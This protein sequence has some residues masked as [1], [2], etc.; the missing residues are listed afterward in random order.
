MTD[1]ECKTT[2]DQPVW[3]FAIGSMMNSTSLRGRKLYPI[4]SKPCIIQ[5]FRLE[6]LGRNG[7]AGAIAASGQSFHGVA[8]LMKAEQMKVLDTIESGYLRTPATA[9][10]YDEAKT[11]LEVSVYVMDA[12]KTNPDRL[13]ADGQ[14]K[15]GIPS[16]RYI[17]IL[18]L[19]CEEFGVSK[20]HVDYLK[21]ITFK[22]RTEISRLKSI[23]VPEKHQTWTTKS[24]AET[25]AQSTEAMVFAV[26]G[27]VLKD[28][29][30][31][32]PDPK[33]R[34]TYF[35]KSKGT[36]VVWN[37]SQL[38][39]DPKY[40]M[41]KTIHEMSEEHKVVIEDFFV[42]MMFKEMDEESGIVSSKSVEVIGVVVEDVK[43]IEIDGR[44]TLIQSN[45]LP[46]L[47][48]T[49]VPLNNTNSASITLIHVEDPKG[50]VFSQRKKQCDLWEFVWGK[51]KI[52]FLF[53]SNSST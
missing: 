19:G 26:N 53:F 36:D 40:G 38:L 23:P 43:D 14:I 3:Y 33:K 28:R 8:H 31:D 42:D 34:L 48:T 37:V 17:D 49:V 25:F 47:A 10:L 52:I 1:S 9:L 5:N 6:F 45:D 20:L 21:N 12:T 2:E 41:P 7:M 35:Q 22:P 27:K 4:E 29:N 50:G 18:L 44:S 24:L 16:E 15:K 13:D 46:P 11:E 51:Q 39:F 32:D 30:F